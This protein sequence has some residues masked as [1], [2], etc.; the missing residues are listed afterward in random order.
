MGKSPNSSLLL[1]L[2]RLEHLKRLKRG[3]IRRQELK[4]NERTQSSPNKILSL[5]V[6]IENTII[7]NFLFSFVF[8]A[9]AHQT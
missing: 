3:T 5:D 7:P 4:M 2:E 9:G 8:R 6:I 1:T